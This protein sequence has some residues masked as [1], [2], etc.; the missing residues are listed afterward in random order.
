MPDNAHPDLWRMGIV[1]GAA[2]R[3]VT[4]GQNEQFS[5]ILQTKSIQH[6]LDVRPDR[7]ALTGLRGG[8][9]AATLFVFTK[10]LS[11]KKIGILYGAGE[12]GFR[13]RL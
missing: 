8:A 2:E 12:H 9:D 10:A 4:G 6:W 5:G 13:R 11:V 7:G 1:L 3:D